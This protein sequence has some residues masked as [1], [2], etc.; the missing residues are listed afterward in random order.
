LVQACIKSMIDDLHSA[1]SMEKYIESL[2]VTL[3][4]E[5][6]KAWHDKQ[7]ALRN[8]YFLRQV[9]IWWR[10]NWM[11]ADACEYPYI[12]EGDYIVLNDVYYMF[13]SYGGLTEMRTDNPFFEQIRLGVRADLASVAECA[14]LWCDETWNGEEN[15]SWSDVIDDDTDDDVPP[16]SKK[17]CL[18][19]TRLNV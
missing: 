12:D 11:E 15:N 6:R 10:N 16:P 18:F 5:I 13:D 2:P 4:V 7:I 17:H 1:E 14:T 3:K 19:P 9:R 8:E